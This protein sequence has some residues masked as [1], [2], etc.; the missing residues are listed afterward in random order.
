MTHTMNTRIRAAKRVIRTTTLIP[1]RRIHT[2]TRTASIINTN[3][4]RKVKNQKTMGDVIRFGVSMEDEL[5]KSFDQLVS[6]RGYATRSEAL[7]DLIRDALVQ[8][9]LAASEQ[10]SE[11]LGSLT[12]VY[13]HHA[14][15]LTGQMAEVQ[16]AHH[17]LVVSV[18][19]VHISEQDCME[20]IVLRGRSTEV[21]ALA[22]SLLSLKG[23]KHGKL[24]VTFPSHAITDRTGGIASHTHSHVRGSTAVHRRSG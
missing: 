19:H 9:R 20:V 11:V 2:N 21:R 6:A 16:H 17:G 4:T 7:R 8:S 22:N 24:F 5:L 3:M 1:A 18:L 10:A 13:D 23:V 12:L 14:H 15:D